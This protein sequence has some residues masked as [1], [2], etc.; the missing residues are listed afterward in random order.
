MESYSVGKRY[1]AYK[2]NHLRFNV[3]TLKSVTNMEGTE[4]ELETLLIKA[5]YE[6]YLLK[7]VCV[8]IKLK[9]EKKS[10]CI[11]NHIYQ[12]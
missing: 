8:F 9:D 7:Q 3:P 10:K 1:Y 2:E 11:Y 6:N 4:N 12:I 5:V